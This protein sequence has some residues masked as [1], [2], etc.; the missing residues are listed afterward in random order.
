MSLCLL[1]IIFVQGY[2]I[3]N[4]FDNKEDQF[5]YNVR[6][7]L[8]K[9]SSELQERELEYY[10]RLYNEVADSIGKTDGSTFRE[11]V[12]TRADNSTN[13]TFIYSSGI[14]EEDYK[15]AS[16][17]L[18]VDFDSIDFKKLY[19]RKFTTTVRE[20]VD[21][22]QPS[23]ESSTISVKRLDENEQFQ[24]RETFKD[25]AQR[26]PIHKRVNVEEIRTLINHQLETRAL[27]PEFEF[28]IFSNGLSTKIA[29]ENFV[30]EPNSSNVYSVPLFLDENRNFKYELLV[31][32]SK[33]QQD[34][35]SSVLGMG[36]LTLLLTTIIILAYYSAIKQIIRQRQISEIKTDFINNMTH[37]FK[38]PI[39]TINLALDAM[40][41]PKISENKETME[42]YLKMIRE[43]NKRM[44]AQVESVLRISKLEK[45]DLNIKKERLKLHDL[46][47]DAITHVELLVE[48]RGGYIK[49]HF[50]ALKSSVLANESHFTNV[51]VNILDN[52]IKYSPEAPKIDIFTE[53]VKNNI[54]LKIRDQGS[55]MSKIA[56]KKIFEKFYR[57]HTGNVHNV[58]GHGLGLSYVKR[59]VD[60]HQGQIYVESEKGKGSTF[61]IKLQLIS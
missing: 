51:V 9:V 34:V 22:S 56:Q 25:I 3:K 58:K 24:M 2:W 20:G 30:H 32:F 4:S 27:K 40:K 7:T 17:F 33:K 21:G 48:D 26:I 47:D 31:N 36:I 16:N 43:E 15:L 8:I 60:D 13:E 37:E 10:Y 61:I 23:M 53:N 6:Q 57:E 5:V 12:Y 35:Y 49:T 18:D 59:M 45:N 28:A 41:N 39:A 29:S 1:G 50:G 38:T 14:L 19:N 11:I 44:H 55:G 42:R 52:A 54:I 46:I